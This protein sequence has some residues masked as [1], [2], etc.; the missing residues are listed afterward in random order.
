MEVTVACAGCSNC[1][2]RRD[3]QR[4]GRLERIAKWGGSGLSFVGS[5]ILATMKGAGT[6]PLVFLLLLVA[7]TA[8]VIAGLA[9]R[10]RAVVTSSL[11]GMAFN[12]SATLIRL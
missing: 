10:D 4:G 11:F 5:L 12:L 1:A 7:S 2:I 6:S 3:C 8:W 9:M